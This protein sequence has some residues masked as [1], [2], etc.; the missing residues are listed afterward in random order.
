[1]PEAGLDREAGITLLDRAAEHRPAPPHWAPGLATTRSTPPCPGT[2]PPCTSPPTG[3]QMIQPPTAPTRAYARDHRR[4]RRLLPQR[5]WLRVTQPRLSPNAADRGG[6]PTCCMALT[7]ARGGLWD[8]AVGCV[9]GLSFLYE[10]TGRDGDGP[11]SSPASSPT[12][13]TPDRRA[14]ARPR[15]QLGVSSPATRCGL[16]GEHGLAH[17]NRP[18]ERTRSAWHRDQA[19]LRRWLLPTA[20]LTPAQR[21]Q[22]RNLAFALNELGMIILS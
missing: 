5:S 11:G 1:M 22:I 14:T 4:T 2:S 19:P 13:P 21:N 18:P 7:C 10:R 3:S 8:A 12:S 20:S 6:R 16:R 9:P 17:R 15:R